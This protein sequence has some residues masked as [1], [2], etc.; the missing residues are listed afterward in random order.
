MQVELFGVWG[1]ILGRKG[2]K[3][4]GRSERKARMNRGRFFGT[5]LNRRYEKEIAN[6]FVTFRFAPLLQARATLE[7]PSRVIVTAVSTIIS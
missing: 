6:R 1:L 3:L 2:G 4:K 7:D 5:G